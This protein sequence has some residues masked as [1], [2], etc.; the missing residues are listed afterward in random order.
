MNSM[1]FTKID[2]QSDPRKVKG[3]AARFC[4]LTEVLA[5]VPHLISLTKGVEYP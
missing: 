2:Y 4:E 1:S 5:S 3:R